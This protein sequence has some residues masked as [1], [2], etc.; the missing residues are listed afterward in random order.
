MHKVKKASKVEYLKYLAVQVGGGMLNLLVFMV[1]L[2]FFYWMN[3]LPILPLAIG[4]L[5][6]MSFNYFFSGVW[7]FGTGALK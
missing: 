1:L 3:K 4:A 6:G 5:F 7:V 2:H